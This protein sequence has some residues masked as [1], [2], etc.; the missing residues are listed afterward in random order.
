MGIEFDLSDGKEINV[1]CVKCNTETWHKVLKSVFE[2]DANDFATFWSDSQII[3]CQGCREITFRKVTSNDLDILGRDEDGNTI[4]DESQTLYP[5][6]IRGRKR[7]RG[8]Y[9]LPKDVAKIYNETYQAISSR[10]PILTGM[11]IRALVEAVCSEKKTKGKDLKQRIDNLVSL[12]VLT[13]DGARI[14]D[15]TRLYG[16][17]AAHETV[18]I[19]DA[20]INVLMDIA[21]NLLENVYILPRNASKLKSKKV[22]KKASNFS[23]DF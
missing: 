22:T 7:I 14:L 20:D 1:A 13:K 3:M 4:F 16:N 12:G 19:E 23:E 15:H 11:G 5:G 10:Q 6:R 21:E 2:T 17:R 18:A 9:G 8:Y